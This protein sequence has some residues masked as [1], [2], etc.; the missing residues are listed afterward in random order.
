MLD[1]LFIDRASPAKT[2]NQHGPNDEGS[3]V[4]GDDLRTD[5]SE[6]LARFGSFGSAGEMPSAQNEEGH[7]K[8][9]QVFSQWLSDY[10]RRDP[11]APPATVE[12][13]A[14]ETAAGVVVEVH[15]PDEQTR[16]MLAGVEPLVRERLAQH[17]IALDQITVAKAPAAPDAPAEA[18]E[19]GPARDGEPVQMPGQAATAGTLLAAFEDRLTPSR[20]RDLSEIESFMEGLGNRIRT[21]D[22]GTHSTVPVETDQEGVGGTLVETSGS[23]GRSGFFTQSLLGP[24]SGHTPSM[25]P[26]A[27]AAHLDRLVLRAA[28]NDGQSLRIELHPASLGR[29]T[30]QCRD[31]DGVL[32]V[33]ISVQSA[34]VREL[35]LGQES[36][37]RAALSGQGL[38]L[39]QFNVSSR[40]QQG[41]P[42]GKQTPRESSRVAGGSPHSRS[43][44]TGPEALPVSVWTRNHWVG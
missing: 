19:P 10:F 21:H 39:G 30:V 28:R 37:L 26:D 23:M 4:F 18:R 40:D 32:S 11:A 42:S 14:R 22:R 27:L 6:S 17:G 43:E 12:V 9:D 24:Q 16:A 38:S 7:L 31:A 36:D 25:D 44:M 3:F 35:L 5:D 13:S 20:L 29:V 15:A 34:S 1:F 2:G 41:R 33:N 8:S